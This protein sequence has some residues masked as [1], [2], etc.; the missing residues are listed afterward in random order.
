VASGSA[1]WTYDSDARAWYFRLAER[2]APPYRTQIKVEA[3]LDLDWE[4]RLAGVE[5]I[6]C[7]PDGAPIEPPTGAGE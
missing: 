5:I 4:G 1:H 3:I 7:K 6:D 2:A